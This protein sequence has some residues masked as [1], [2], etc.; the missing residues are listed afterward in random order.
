MEFEAAR[1]LIE[2]LRVIDS[3]DVRYVSGWGGVL[4][5]LGTALLTLGRT[6]EAVAAYQQAVDMQ[7]AAVHAAPHVARFR[8]FLDNHLA[9]L[10]EAQRQASG[11][12]EATADASPSTAQV[13]EP[14]LP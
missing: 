8:E 9:N 12:A 10:A 3:R 5:N 7:R 4:N 14:E 6:R 1:E 13:M 2:Q 11:P